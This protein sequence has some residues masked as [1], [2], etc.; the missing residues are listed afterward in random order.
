MPATDG[1]EAG[2]ETAPTDHARSRVKASRLPEQTPFDQI[3]AALRCDQ[4]PQQH[5]HRARHPTLPSSHR[6]TAERLTPIACA[7]SFWV[8]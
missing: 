1:A 6:L 5:C 4:H 7:R 3:S 2:E 8:R